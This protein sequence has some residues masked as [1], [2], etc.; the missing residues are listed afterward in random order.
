M[1]ISKGVETTRLGHRHRAEPVVRG[2]DPRGEVVYWVGP[3]G[4]EQDAGLGT[5]FDAVRRGFVSITPLG[6]DLTR[7]STLE[8]TRQWAGKV[9]L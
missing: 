7:H 9:E 1:P 6:V 4:D 5:D 8:L 3:P 2:T